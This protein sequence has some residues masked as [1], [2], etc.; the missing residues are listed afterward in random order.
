MGAAVQ[1][2]MTAEDPGNNFT[3]DVGR[4]DVFRSAEGFGMLKARRNVQES[5][6]CILG[7]RIDSA[8]AYTDAV[9]SP[10]YDSLLVKVIAHARNHQE[11]C[12]KMVRALQEFRI[13]GNHPRC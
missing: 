6:I 4:I 3:P 11:A 1:C 9:I 7:I 13:R 12:A 2:R 10:F 5:T 8:S